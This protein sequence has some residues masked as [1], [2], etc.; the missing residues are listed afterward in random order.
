M[1]WT[2]DD[3]EGHTSHANTPHKRKQWAAVA[4]AALKG[5]HKDASAIRI[6]NA[7]VHKMNEQLDI[8]ERVAK[9]LSEHAPDIYEIMKKQLPEEQS[10]LWIEGKDGHY[11]RKDM[12]AGDTHVTTA[13]GNE[14]KKKKKPKISVAY[15]QQ[16]NKDDE[17]AENA[18]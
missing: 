13:L 9:Y 7:A 5:G 11:Y 12:T 14:D 1:P 15:T 18:I 8:V 4:N 16:N 3:A 6:A 2:A 17:L 10:S